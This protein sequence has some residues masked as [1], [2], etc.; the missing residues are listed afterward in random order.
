MN[1]TCCS[2]PSLHTIDSRPQSSWRRRRYE[3]RNCWQRFTTVEVVVADEETCLQTAAKLTTP[4]G[5]AQNL[6]AEIKAVLA[7]YP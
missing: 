1:I 6:K 4:P 3:C 2:T 5:E 7:K